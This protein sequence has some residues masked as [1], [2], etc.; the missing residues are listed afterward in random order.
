MTI[1]DENFKTVQF[2]TFYF[3]IINDILN[4]S[5]QTLSANKEIKREF[6]LHYC[7]LFLNW[8][9]LSSKTFTILF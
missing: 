1:Y 2:I 4:A 6:R 7:S 5:V 3:D 8:K 9:V